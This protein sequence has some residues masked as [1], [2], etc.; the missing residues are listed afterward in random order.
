MV[1]AKE[2]GN[3]EKGFGNWVVESGLTEEKVS[4]NDG[5]FCVTVLNK[6]P[7]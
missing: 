4:D 7:L 5:M 3:W 2:K 6:Q 1:S